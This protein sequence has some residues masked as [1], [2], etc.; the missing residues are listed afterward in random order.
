[1]IKGVIK[2]LIVVA[3]ANALFH[4]ASAYL[5]YF[6]FKDAV[7]ELALHSADKSESQIKEKVIELAA[8]YGEPLD[9]QAVEVRRNEEHTFIEGRYTKTVALFPGYEYPWPF[10]INVDGFVIRPPELH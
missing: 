8:T 7:S 10:S 1:M 6:R 2:L 4:V 9:V 3:V 5:S